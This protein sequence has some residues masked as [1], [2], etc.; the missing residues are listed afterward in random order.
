MVS[1]HFSVRRIENGVGSFF[2]VENGVGSFF[3]E[4]RRWG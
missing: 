1:V 4:G 3:G 2:G